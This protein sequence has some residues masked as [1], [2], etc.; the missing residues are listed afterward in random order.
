M[1]C[2]YCLLSSQYRRSLPDPFFTGFIFCNGPTVKCLLEVWHNAFVLGLWSSF[3]CS[4]RIQPSPMLSIFLSSCCKWIN[5][6][7][8]TCSSKEDCTGL[9]PPISLCVNRLNDRI[10]YCTTISRKSSKQAATVAVFGQTAPQ[11]NTA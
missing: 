7:I 9:K 6:V 2:H 10:I 5:G 3:S 4:K 8:C 1:H 11:M